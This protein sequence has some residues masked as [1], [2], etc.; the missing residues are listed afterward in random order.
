MDHILQQCVFSRQVWFR[1]IARM[2]LRIELCPANDSRLVQ[3]W[4]EARKHI[5]K[6]TRKGFDTFVM[7]ICWTLWKQRNARVFR[8]T[9]DVRDARGTMEIIFQELKLWE[10]AGG[11][12]VSTFCE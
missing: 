2:G 7:L 11:S 12:G 5:H 4:T 9:N 6:Q 1:C 10:L 3:W 8:N